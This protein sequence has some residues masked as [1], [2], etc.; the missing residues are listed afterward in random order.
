MDPIGGGSRVTRRGSISDG[1][2]EGRPG[3][4][5]ADFELV[6][7]DG[8]N[9]LHRVRGMRD[10]AGLRWLLPRLRAWLPQGSRALV[11]L[12]G[13]PDPGDAL[14]R[15][16]ATGV[17]FQHSG[18]VD[19]DTRLVQTLAARPYADRSRTV[20]VT[21]D[22]ALR[23]RV[24]QT[25]GLVRRLDWLTSG[26]AAAVGEPAVV[27]GGARSATRRAWVSRAVAVGRGRA[28]RSS[29]SPETPVDGV[30]EP[31]LDG[32]AADEGKPWKAGR[33]ATRKRGNPKR[34]H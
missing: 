22:R 4:T 20:V 26:L 23:D 25:G 6:L 9:L 14:R 28:P 16:V 10:E 11:M 7:I 21:D 2:L 33:G 15:R 12:D 13:Q 8:D 19:A 3:V 31:G 1:G 24:R 5:F 17:E 30:R 29:G 27:G 18:N 34:G 32:T